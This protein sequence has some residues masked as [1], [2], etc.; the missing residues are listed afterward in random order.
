MIVRQ[1]SFLAPVMTRKTGLLCLFFACYG[2]KRI[3]SIIMGEGGS[4]F[5]RGLEKNNED[6]G[7]DDYECCID[8]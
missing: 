8:Q 7:T 6:C 2:K 4:R 5:F 3:V 1:R